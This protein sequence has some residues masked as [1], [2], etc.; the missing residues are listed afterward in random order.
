[1]LNCPFPWKSSCEVSFRSNHST[2]FC[3]APPGQAESWHAERLMLAL[4]PAL[5]EPPCWPP[6]AHGLGAAAVPQVKY[7]V[8]PLPAIEVLP[9]PPK[10]PPA[11][12]YRPGFRVH[13]PMLL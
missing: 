7:T 11:I 2:K 3:T 12:T 8:T 13:D 4:P 5:I 1:M 9:F 6:D 10:T